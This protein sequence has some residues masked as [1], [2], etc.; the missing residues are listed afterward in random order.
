MEVAPR[1]HATKRTQH[2]PAARIH[3]GSVPRTPQL[4]EWWPRQALCLWTARTSQGIQTVVRYWS[5]KRGK[6]EELL[7]N[8]NGANEPNLGGTHTEQL[9]APGT[10]TARPDHRS[11]A[12]HEKRSR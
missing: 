11:F 4:T 12:P 6:N 2:R 1:A 5:L 8:R 9:L 7:G 3:G 10:K